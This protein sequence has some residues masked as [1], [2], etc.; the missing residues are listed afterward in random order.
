MGYDPEDLPREIPL[1]ELGLDSLMAVRIK[2]RVEYEFDIPQLQLQAMRQ[3]NLADV[4]KFV[5]FAVTHRDQLDDLA[6][7]LPAE[8]NS[9]PQR[10]T[11]TSTSR[12]PRTRPPVPATE[13]SPE[14][15]QEVAEDVADVEVAVATSPGT[16][17][18]PVKR[19]PTSPRRRR[20]R[21]PP[22]RMSRRAMRPSG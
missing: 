22:V 21:R 17:P 18:E 5:E 20:S 11:P 6:R 8:V 12:T 16:N 10:S 4:Q 7:T 3:A 2:N 1:I 13:E 19:P 14:P 9:T 15:K